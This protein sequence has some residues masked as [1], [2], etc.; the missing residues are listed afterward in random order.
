MG[1]EIQQILSAISNL[2]K[3]F[4]S[5]I[6]K[7]QK[8]VTT[9]QEE[10][11][12]EVVKRI[13]K[14]AYQFQKKGNE[15][16]FMFNS[17]VEEHIETVKKEMAKVLPS[18]AAD[19]KTALTK[20]M[21]KLN[22][23]T[24]VIAV[25]QKHIKIADHSELGW[26]V[27]AAYENDDL[28]KNSDNERRLFKAEKEAERRQQKKKRKLNPTMGARKRSEVGAGP[29]VPAGRGGG[30][31]NRPPPARPRLIGPCFRCGEFG[32]L[33]ASCPKP[34]L[35]YPLNQPLVSK[36]VDTIEPI[37]KLCDNYKKEFIGSEVAGQSTSANGNVV[38]TLRKLAESAMNG[39]GT[40][41]GQGTDELN[42]G[43]GEEATTSN[44]GLNVSETHQLP[45]LGRS[46]EVEGSSVRLQVTDVQ[47]RLRQAQSFWK[48][49]LQASGLIMDWILTGYKLPLLCAPTPFVQ[50]NHRSS[51]EHAGF[52]TVAVQELMANR[53]VKKVS[54]KP[55][56][57]S[58]LS[59]EVNSEGKQRLVLN[60]KHLNQFLRKDKFKYE[61][62]RVALLMF[63]KG[64]FLFKFDLKSGYHQVDIYEPHQ[65]YL[66]FAWEVEGIVT[67][68]VFT[69]L[70]FG[71][72]S[73]CY[74]FT[75]LLRPLVRY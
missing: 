5:S 29:E 63:Q 53:C 40:I 22:E 48:E 64:D 52:V 9:G 11:S 46:W 25:R 36:A 3:K 50:G 59:V 67:F 20:A 10:T 41:L 55:F 34:R 42:P 1:K 4:F 21:T 17:T 57:C 74:A 33:V 35:M 58:P 38:N 66:G 73:A 30:A 28:A 60:L 62:L 26:G 13:T 24:K 2:D 61:D 6:A 49:T 44:V 32:H 43:N 56:V 15:A 47:G 19:Q 45:D 18:A 65:R 51:L 27:V 39:C 7:L 23:G 37:V 31:G 16:Q 14:R 70:P 8:E 72:S 69:V 54:E 71:L 68:F 12:Q 75:K